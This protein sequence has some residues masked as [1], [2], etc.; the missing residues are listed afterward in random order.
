MKNWGGG[1]HHLED[2]AEYT[3]SRFF[4]GFGAGAGKIAVI[5]GSGAIERGEGGFDPL[6]S[7]GSDAMGSDDIADAFDDAREDDDVKAVLFRVDSPGGSTLASELIRRSVEVTAKKKPVVVSMSGYAASGGYW[8][9]LPAR[10][11]LADAGTITGSIG[12]LGGKFNIAPATE[13]IYINSGG[14]SRGANFEMFD[15]FTDFTPA[16]QKL[17]E[18]Q[19]LGDDYKYFLKVVA[20]D[21]HMTIEQVDGVARGRVWTG[22]KAKEIKLVDSIGTFD[23]ALAKAKEFA[24]M[25]ADEVVRIEEL[26]TQPGLI[27]SLLEGRMSSAMAMAISPAQALAPMA[28][29]LR[30]MLSGYS[31]FRAAY[32]PIM[33]VL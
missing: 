16:Q 23:D 32:C 13:K 1:H 8:V 19:M 14:I 30:A 33:P 24:G 2:Y 26:P 3:R 10:A 28:R 5:Y 25:K 18:E 27:E 31:S 29:R 9:S 12:V 20:A 15:S 22:R 11:I 17:F 4:D 6:L 21:R 7:P